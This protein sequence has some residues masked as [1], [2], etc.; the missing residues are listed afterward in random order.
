MSVS[1]EPVL[2]G[3]IALPVADRVEPLCQLAEAHVEAGAGGPSLAA[4]LVDLIEAGAGMPRQRLRLGEA[5]G[6]LGDPRLLRPGDPSYWTRVGVDEHDIGIGCHMV[7]TAEFREFLTDGYDN[8]DHWCEAGRAWRD[9]GEPTWAVLAEDD[10]VA[11][12]VVP[13][14]PVV[15]VNWF[16]ASAYARA[17]G[18]RLLT[19]FER[20]WVVRGV[21]KRPYP[22]GQ[23]FG[24]GNANTRE[25]AL[26]KPCAI[27]LFRSDCT[28]DGVWDL[29]GNAAEWLSDGSNDEKMLHP[30]SWVRP[31]MAAWAKAL[32]MAK[33]NTRSADLGFRL[34]R[35]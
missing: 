5:L 34:A 22:W 24:A 16:E 31:S 1:T 18:A 3:I 11:H 27:G 33:P 4:A 14:Q 26:G 25:E 21:P 30:G 2:Q 13:N 28:P 7:S 10:E 8:I 23:P 12:L 17:C 19:T 20:R 6:R 32:E 29:A 15:G 35:N 9:S